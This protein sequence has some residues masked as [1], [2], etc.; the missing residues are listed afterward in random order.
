MA[1]NHEDHILRSWGTN[2]SPW[3]EAVRE[4]QIASRRLVT[5]KAV[6]DAVV[7]RA[8]GTVL[9]IGCGEGWLARALAERA[10][11]VTGVDA[12]PELIEQARR[13]GNAEY[14]VATYEQIAAGALGDLQ[15]DLVVI[16]FALIGAESVDNLIRYVPRLLTPGG[17]LVIQTLHPVVA[18][19]ELPYKEG[20]R[21]GSWAGFNCHFSDPPPWY[22]RTLESWVRLIVNS[23]LRLVE[24]REPVHPETGKPASVIF[25]AVMN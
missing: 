25:V 9:D 4:D 24:L 1:L 5:N 12:I 11:Q 17:A 8:P 22:F 15:V 19:G 13:A 2:A 23:G 20:W 18:G 14:R 6:I 7:D 10:I 21:E 3:T 16:N